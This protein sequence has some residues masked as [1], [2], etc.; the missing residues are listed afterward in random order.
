VAL[1][2][3]RAAA[4]LGLGGDVAVVTPFL[5]AL[6]RGAGALD[7]PRLAVAPEAATR[8]AGGGAL[9][10]AL[11]RAAAARVGLAPADAARVGLAPADAARCLRAAAAQ[12]ALEP[13][14]RTPDVAVAAGALAAAVAEGAG[15]LGGKALAGA[16]V[17]AAALG[18]R[19]GGGGAPLAAALLASG[20]RFESAS[21]A[22]HALAALVALG[23]REGRLLRT[24]ADA[25][26]EA[27]AKGAPPAPTAAAAAVEALRGGGGGSGAWASKGLWELLEKRS[28]LAAK[29]KR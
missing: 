24:L 3:L 19:G 7:G 10:A 16:A 15:A 27:A 8:L 2:C 9:A 11:L 12:G 4:A 22:C 18:A 29:E 23:L 6:T 21:D 25:V 13:T 26:E 14:P 1:S 17:A 20:H 28:A 5:D